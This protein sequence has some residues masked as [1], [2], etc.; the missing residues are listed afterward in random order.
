MGE[1]K[2]NNVRL[3]FK[4]RVNS[5]FYNNFFLLMCKNFHNPTWALFICGSKLDMDP[6]RLHYGHLP[7]HIRPMSSKAK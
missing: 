3:C 1:Q 6:M 7:I 4:M 5:N 2:I